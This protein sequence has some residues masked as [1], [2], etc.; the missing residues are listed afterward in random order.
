MIKISDQ[1]QFGPA[2]H[3]RASPRLYSKW[4][5]MFM[6]SVLVLVLVPVPQTSFA[7]EYIRAEEP[8]P[9]SVDELPDAME[10]KSLEEEAE[11]LPGRGPLYRALKKHLERRPPFWRDSRLGFNFRTYESSL[12]TLNGDIPE[13]WAAGGELEFTSGEWNE[14]L[15]VSMG[16]YTSQKIFAS[17]GDGT[18]LLDTDQSEI[19][20][21]GK[22][23][24][25]LRY[26]DILAR[27][28]RQEF[29][30]ITGQWPE[31]TP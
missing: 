26:Q 10:F 4:A 27:L 18:R 30:T 19:T 5:K 12:K 23:Y 9:K 24:L 28:Y 21:L 25:Q 17:G 7:R 29:H 22:A 15:S 3:W 13:A 20:V 14:M 16:L 31:R 1:N 2:S 8:A 11:D 6:I